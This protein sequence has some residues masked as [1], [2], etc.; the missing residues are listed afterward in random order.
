MTSRAGCRV[1]FC[2]SFPSTLPHGRFAAPSS[3]CQP[4]MPAPAD[5]PPVPDRSHLYYRIFAAERTDNVMRDGRHFQNK[6]RLCIQPF[7]HSDD[8][9]IGLDAA[10]MGNVV[11]VPFRIGDLL[12]HDLCNR[13]PPFSS[14]A[15]CFKT[16][17]FLKSRS[18]PFHESRIF[19]S[20]SRFTAS[21]RENR[22]SFNRLPRIST[23]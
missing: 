1:T 17:A 15:I 21:G 13:H 9:G 22:A 2:F 10:Q 19:K 5:R 3:R 18:S 7:Q 23:L 14:S 20:A 11:D 12:F 8:S 4:E 16:A 6:L